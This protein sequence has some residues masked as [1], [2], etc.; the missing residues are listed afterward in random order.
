MLFVAGT[1]PRPVSHACA[2]A[3]HVCVRACVRT[4]V[5]AC[6]CVCVYGRSYT[7]LSVSTPTPVDDLQ[8]VKR[9]RCSLADSGVTV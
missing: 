6:V 9:P 7:V 5:S 4:G 8:P 2:Y 3:V 1:V